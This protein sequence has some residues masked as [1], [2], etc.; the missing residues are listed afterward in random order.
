MKIEEIIEELVTYKEQIPKKA[1]EEALKKKEEIIPKLLEMLDYTKKHLDD[2]LDGKD[3]F[4]GYVFAYFLLAEFREVKAFPYLVDLVKH[5]DEVLE[6]ILGDDYLGTLP[7][8]LA[9]TY[10]G[11]DE[12]IY[13]LIENEE[14]DEFT[15]SAVLQ[16][17]AILYFNGDK[18]REFLVDYLRE[19]LNKRK[20]NNNSYLY[21]DILNIV[22]D[23]KLKELSKDVDDLFSL[24]EN[25]KERKELKNYLEDDTPINRELF[26][27]KPFYEYMYNT[28]ELMEDWDCFCVLEDK[29]YERSEE[30]LEC[31]SIIRQRLLNFR[32]LKK[33]VGRNEL[34][35][36]GS[37]KK[38]KKCCMN[39][40]DDLSTLDLIDKFVSKAEWYLNKKEDKKAY[41]FFRVAWFEVQ[42]L[43]EK[44]NIKS[45]F[46]YDNRYDS[47]DFLANWLQ[48]Y[49]EI[50][51]NSDEK[52]KIYER[53]E[54][55][56]TLE[57]MFD[58]NEESALYFKEFFIRAK[59][60]AYFKLNNIVEARRIILDYLEEKPT[61][62]WGYV[63]MADWYFLEKDKDLEKARD[64]LLKAE[65]VTDIEEPTVIYERLADIYK[66][67]GDDELYQK[68]WNKL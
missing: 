59:A 50:L 56:N 66:E 64:I 46:E 10:N 61:W 7:R 62:V 13:S 68:Y 47:F 45:I 44:N 8:L 28:I 53:I 39:I 65:A 25:E 2:I 26:P 57:R 60:N 43:C 30:Y 52:N 38:Y 27:Y 9:S 48:Y 24:I 34:C 23:L 49:D 22:S 11:D 4:F 33:G 19:L 67:L 1:L 20:D 29:E 41:K 54:L 5:D 55:C 51:E 32:A 15:R 31:Q 16:V 3:D 58:L 36:C 17:F 18:T 40:E 35:L 12:V 63:E 42:H 6:F 14:L 21:I 37:G